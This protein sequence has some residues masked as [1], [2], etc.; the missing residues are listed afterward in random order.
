M[1]PKWWE[2]PVDLSQYDGMT[3]EEI[4]RDMQREWFDLRK[5]MTAN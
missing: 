5:R 2:A 1:D 4:H 3:Q